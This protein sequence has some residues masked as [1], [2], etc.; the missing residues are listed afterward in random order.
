M[1]GTSLSWQTLAMPATSL[2]PPKYVGDVMS[3]A[4]TLGKDR[5]SGIGCTGLRMLIKM[6]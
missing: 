1:S 4:P 6:C 3:T 5:A 2:H